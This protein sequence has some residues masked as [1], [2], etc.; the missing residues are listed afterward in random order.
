MV[1]MVTHRSGLHGE[2]QQYLDP[3]GIATISLGL[4]LSRGAVVKKHLVTTNVA[5][6]VLQ[7]WIFIVL[8]KKGIRIMLFY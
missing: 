3:R 1:T 7:L 8:I 6:F 2:K 5:K 4:T